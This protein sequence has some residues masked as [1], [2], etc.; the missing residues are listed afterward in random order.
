VRIA[1]DGL[2]YVCDRLNNR[3][4]VF[5]TNGTFVKEFSVEPTTAGNG[6]VWDIA[7]SRDAGQKYL[8]MADGR[9]NR[10]HVLLRETGA[11]L[12]SIGRPGRYAG[13]FHWVHDLAIDSSGNLYAGEV[14]NGKRVQKFLRQP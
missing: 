13:E 5:R 10:V 11:V 4:Q 7:I 2:V 3:V 14:D 9:N 6:A 8:L 1:K 12:S